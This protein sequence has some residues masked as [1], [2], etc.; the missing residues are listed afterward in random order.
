VSVLYLVLGLVV[1]QRLGELALAAANT[2]RLLALG[3]FEIDRGGYPLFV[4]LHAGW[5]AVLA[6]LVSPATSP[7]WP[8]LG[9]YAVLQI[10]RVWVIATL[11]GR[12]T[13]RLI[14]L[15]HAPLV[16]GGP[17]R[18]CR[19]PNYLVVAGEIAILP[20]AFGAVGTA[21]LFSLANLA[22]TARRIRIEDRVLAGN[23]SAEMT[24][25]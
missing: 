16:Q 21:I 1:L 11:G 9:L 25:P 6:L 7:I 10:G 23:L 18:F 24:Q 20:L 22:L 13:T 3:G 12:W 4:A 17:Y 19:H 8:L 15:P 5:L 14:A 2:R